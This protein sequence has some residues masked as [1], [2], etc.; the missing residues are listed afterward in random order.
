MRVILAVKLAVV[1]EVV[2][3]LAATTVVVVSHQ[4]IIFSNMLLV[5]LESLTI[6]SALSGS[7]NNLSSKNG[8]FSHI[9]IRKC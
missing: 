2:V 3:A 4:N 8:K 5:K 6:S 7:I 1:L 9:I